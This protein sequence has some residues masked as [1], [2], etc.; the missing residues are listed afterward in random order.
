MISRVRTTRWGIAVAVLAIV[1]AACGGGS[2]KSSSG[3]SSSSGKT[4][5]LGTTDQ[6]SVLDPA[7][8]YDL[9]DW[10]I[11]YNVFQTLLTIP[12]G[13]NTPIPDAA[14]GCQFVNA[15]TYG[16][17]LKPG[18][19]FSNG[20][21]LTSADVKFSFDRMLKINDP[22]GPASLFTTLK[23]VTVVNPTDFAFTLT[24]HDNTFPFVL[25]TG[26]GAIVDS[27][28]F[29]LAS[30]N[31]NTPATYIGSGPY[32]LVSYTPGQQA[33]FEPNPNYTGANKPQNKRFI[34]QFYT[35]GSALKQAIQQ[36]AVDIAFRGLSPQD[37]TSLQSQSG[38]TVVH[39]QGAEIRYLVFETGRAP[40]NNVH[41]RRAIAY[42]IDRQ[43][44]AQTVYNGTVDPLYSMIAVGLVGHTD[45]FKTA[46][47]ASPDLNKAKQEM[48]MSGLHTPVSFTMWYTPT[49]YGA[50]SAAEY[51]EIKRELEAS[52]LFKVTL[53]STEWAAY[54]K[55]YAK[56]QYQAYQLG[57]FPDF[58]DADDYVGQFYAKDGGFEH[59][60]YDNPQEDALLAKEKSE[61]NPQQRLAEFAQIQQI[62]TQDVPQIPYFQAQ[63]IGVA[64]TSIKGLKDTFDPSYI[65][66]FW[67]ISKS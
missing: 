66:R 31:P 4:I 32:K 21:P 20:D 51:T 28:V 39:G 22:D 15:T 61:S 44:I 2:K 62:G 37:I 54:K 38:L 41:F 24:E 45:S 18:L 59:N 52:G 58:P 36:G 3:G 55:A 34:E 35:T 27:K 14:V 33:V 19:K 49:H 26:A 64:K 25:T 5:V 12:A 63:Q 48:Q 40:G 9:P 43:Q 11:I 6:P 29:K 17:R 16:C 57:W 65:F 53:Q 13:G 23:A 47:G 1:L 30:K 67:L 56:H 50:N 46:Y 60:Q 10:N 42:L 7:G 8:A